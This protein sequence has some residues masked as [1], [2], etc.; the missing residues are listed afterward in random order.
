MF[1]NF[2]YFLIFTASTLLGVNIQHERPS[3]DN[4][5]PP[6]KR[7]K[8]ALN[9]LCLE[10]NLDDID[11]ILDVTK[12]SKINNLDDESLTAFEHLMKYYNDYRINKILN[13]EI[14]EIDIN[15][16]KNILKNLL[17]NQLK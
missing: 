4:E 16:F 1:N 14:N 2:F 12:D 3:D 5:Q 10:G 15:K 13:N 11:T 8:S 7:F 17:I 6:Q 9:K